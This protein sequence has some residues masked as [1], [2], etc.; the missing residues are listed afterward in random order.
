MK[1]TLIQVFSPSQ[2]TNKH[3]NKQIASM[4]GSTCEDFRPHRT[5]ILALLVQTYFAH[6]SPAIRRSFACTFHQKNTPENMLSPQKIKLRNYNCVAIRISRM[7]S[8]L[9]P[10]NDRKS[11]PCGLSSESRQIPVAR[12]STALKLQRAISLGLSPWD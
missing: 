6:F 11:H 10:A 2:E 8:L 12:G 7:F 4:G 5:S 9:R 1:V 3:R